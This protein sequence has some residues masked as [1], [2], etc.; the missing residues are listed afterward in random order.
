MIVGT[1]TAAISSMESRANNDPLDLLMQQPEETP[2][3]PLTIRPLDLGLGGIPL[4]LFPQNFH[5]ERESTLSVDPTII[6]IEPFLDPLWNP[7]SS[8][9]HFLYNNLELLESGWL[10]SRPTPPALP[11]LSASK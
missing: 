7:T 11:P 10:G 2:L 3:L 8:T 5:E 9:E 6:H 1:V 4:S